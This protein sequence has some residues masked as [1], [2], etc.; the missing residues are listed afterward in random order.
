[1][2]TLPYSVTP[3]GPQKIRFTFWGHDEKWTNKWTPKGQILSIRWQV[4]QTEGYRRAGEVTMRQ[5]SLLQMGLSFWSWFPVCCGLKGKHTPPGTAGFSHS[6][7]LAGFYC[8]CLFLT[9]TH[10]GQSSPSSFG[11]RREDWSTLCLGPTL[12]ET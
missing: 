4:S 6:F 3:E 7:H 2:K 12:E 9:R 8:G 11:G 1:M 10:M 5:K